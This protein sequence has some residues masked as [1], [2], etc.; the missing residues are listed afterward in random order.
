[1]PL[2][3]FLVIGAAK[4]AST[5]LHQY[6][7]QHPH[8]Y[9][10]G[11]KEPNYFAFEGG[12]PDFRGPDDADPHA[13]AG[14]E[15]RL[16]VAKYAESITTEET[17]RALFDGARGETAL[18]EASVSYLFFPEA[19][20]RIRETLP[21]AK[22]V[23]LLRN[24]VDRAFSKF[25][26]FRRDGLEPI[27]DFGEA[28][29]AEEDR[30]RDGWSPTWYYQRRGLYHEQLSRY[31]ALFPPEQIL[32][33]LYDDFATDPQAVLRRI[34]RFL[35]VDEN[36][37]P[38][39]SQRHNVSERNVQVP[40]SSRFHRWL[41]EPADLEAMAERRRPGVAARLRRAA[42]RANTR[43]IRWT[44][45]PLSRALRE[46]LVEEFRAD[47]GALARLLG[48]DLSAW[49]AREPPC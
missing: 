42:V 49:L 9:M 23:A 44:H 6:L 1:M 18:G 27:A 2:P 17:Y 10:A 46:R 13:F 31:T 8:I 35:G 3:S 26:Q 15:H 5:S 29:D 36:F 45:E 16:R 12:V 24:P 25:R 41:H 28:L 34:F 20:T 40:R 37:A 48:R 38:N 19:A 7:K 47:V 14:R 43:K 21:A 22:L 33:L 32:V 11:R 30:I 39:L 4:S